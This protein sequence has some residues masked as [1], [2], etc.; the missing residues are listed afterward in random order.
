MH[1]M[2]VCCS[3]YA[4]H[5]EQRL[6]LCIC[7]AATATVAPCGSLKSSENWENNTFMAMKKFGWLLNP[8]L[9]ARCGAGMCHDFQEQQQDFCGAPQTSHYYFRKK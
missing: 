2:L 6:L 3:L 4:Q 7:I 5:I 1:L 8:Q 9:F